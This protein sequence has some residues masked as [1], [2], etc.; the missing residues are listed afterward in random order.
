MSYIWCDSTVVMSK[1]P[2]LFGF[3]YKVSWPA[4]ELKYGKRYGKR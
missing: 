3:K 1:F 2:P 4:L